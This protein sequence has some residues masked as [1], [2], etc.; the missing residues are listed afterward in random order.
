MTPDGFLDRPI[1]AVSLDVGGVLVVPDHG[2]LRSALRRRGIDFDY[3]RFFDAHFHAMAHLD[4]L[5][6]EPESF[7]DYNTG[8]LHASGVPEDQIEAGRAALAELDL[9]PL[10]HQRIPGAIDAG[11]RLLAAGYR[12]AL[13]SN[14]DGTVEE[15]LRRHEVAQVGSGP[16]IPVEHVTDSGILGVH[17]PDP[18]TFM[19]TAHGLGLPPERILHVGDSARFDADGAA[20]VGMVAVHVDPLKWCSDDHHHVSSL[21]ELADMVETAGTV[22]GSA[23]GSD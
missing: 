9:P 1:D 20:R 11:H 8:F 19:A 17:K 2:I 12:L 23:G 21:A 18:A 4:R 3:E 10:W 7:P 16:G 6:A 15:M 14:A 13:T 5:G 22:G